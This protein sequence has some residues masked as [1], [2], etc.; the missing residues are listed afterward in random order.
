MVC[1]KADIC[2]A[3]TNAALGQKDMRGAAGDVYKGS[4]ADIA[5][6]SRSSQRLV[7]FFGLHFGLSAPG[8]P[9]TTPPTV[10]PTTVPTAP[11]TGPAAL[12]PSRPLPRAQSTENSYK[13]KCRLHVYPPNIERS[14]AA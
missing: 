10:P 8:A 3:K 9:F 5:T 11:P 6:A 4:I 7:C 1:E 13:N 2:D 12:F 14:S